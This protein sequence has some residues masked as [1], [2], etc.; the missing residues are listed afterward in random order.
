M[1]K[2]L[3]S[4]LAVAA[5]FCALCGPAAATSR[6]VSAQSCTL[7]EEGIVPLKP[8]SF[9][10]PVQWRRVLGMEGLDRVSDLMALA[11]GGVVGI[12]DSASYTRD[13]GPKPPGL[14]VIRLDRTGKALYD[15]R[16]PLKNYVRAVAGV[17][18]K[19]KIVVVSQM[20]DGKKQ[21]FVQLDFLDGA[22][23]VKTT[24]VIADTKRD[25]IGADIVV[26]ADGAT[27]TLAAMRVGR[28]DAKDSTTVL[29]KLDATGKIISQRDYMPGVATKLVQLQ[30]LPD[31]RLVGAGRIDIGNNRQ[32]GWLLQVSRQGDLLF[33][34]PYARGRQAQLIKAVDDGQGGLYAIGESIPADGS[35]RAAWVMRVNAAGNP[36]WQRFITGKYRYGATDLLVTE[37]G[38]LQML[39]AGRPGQDGGREH[40]RIITLSSV[41]NILEDDAYLEGTNALPS[42][43]IEHSIT[44]KRLMAGMA[45]TGFAEASGPVEQRLATYDAWITGLASLDAFPDPCKSAPA[46]TLDDE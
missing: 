29:Y 44:K 36:V 43:L 32:A 38:R 16:I 25:V 35:Y 4:S 10:G 37:D 6:A 21:S 5:V 11:D 1:Y 14:Y 2:S 33:Q 20:T 18:L 13:G 23:A 15:R 31:G 41:G 42:K 8:P 9:D 22:A 12:G 27:L 3:L 24:R 39:M 30:R 26:N 7:I 17:V 40:A 45:Q 46:E 28:T 19:D 34:R